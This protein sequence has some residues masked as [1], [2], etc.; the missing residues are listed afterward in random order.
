MNFFMA[1]YYLEDFLYMFKSMGRWHS[2]SLTSPSHIYFLFQHNQAFPWGS[3]GNL[4]VAGEVLEM[5]D[6]SRLYDGEYVC[7]ADNGVGHKPVRQSITLK[8]LYPPEVSLENSWLHTGKG[9]TV[10]MACI[11]YSNPIAKVT[12][13]KNTMKLLDGERIHTKNIGNTHKL[14]L[15]NITEKDFGKYS[16]KASNMLEKDVT[17]TLEVTGAPS[18]PL[19]VSDTRSKDRY[20][21]DLSWSVK[22]H[23][24]IK[25]HEAQVW[26][27]IHDGNVPIPP[28][29][30]QTKRI[31]MRIDEDPFTYNIKGLKN[32]TSYDIRIRS[33]NQYG[34]SPYSKTFTFQTLDKEEMPMEVI[35]KPSETGIYEGEGKFLEPLKSEPVTS[36]CSRNLIFI[37]TLIITSS[38]WLLISV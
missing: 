26:A 17:E 27:V 2:M 11:V 21:Y 30:A 16:C 4:T 5:L 37:Q 22:S 15:A 25:I 34:W 35:K 6:I 9:E 13:Y 7:N 1:L 29:T 31:R 3:G 32:N 18:K 10:T 14:S 8:V 23:Y 28:K 24:S 36:R 12:W 33:Q 19:I 38:I 20:S